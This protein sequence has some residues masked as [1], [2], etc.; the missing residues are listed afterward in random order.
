MDQ[1]SFINYHGVVCLALLT[2]E[3]VYGFSYRSYG[4]YKRSRHGLHS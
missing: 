2:R 4:N 1:C 3:I